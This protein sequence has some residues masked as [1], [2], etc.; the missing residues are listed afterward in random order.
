MIKNKYGYYGYL[1]IH[2]RISDIVP[3]VK[4]IVKNGDEFLV[5]LRN[6]HTKRLKTMDKLYFYLGWLL[7]HDSLIK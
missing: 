2:E 3:A 7:S 6:N 4:S 5:T 1:A